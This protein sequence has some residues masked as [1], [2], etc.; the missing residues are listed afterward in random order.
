MTGEL[1]DL[2]PEPSDRKSDKPKVQGGAPRL[3]KPQRDQVEMHFAALDDLLES[4]HPA[5]AVW[6]AVEEL[7]LSPWLREVQAVEGRP[8]RNA[9]DPRV[10]LAVWVYA[11]LEAVGSARRLAKLCDPKG[12]QLGYRW[13][14]GGVTLNYHTLSDFRA[15]NAE[16][17]DGLL[18]QLVATLVH[19]GLVTMN[20]VAQDGMRVKANAGKSSF[21]R[22]VSLRNCLAE[23]KAQVKILRRLIDEDPHELSQREKAAQERAARSRTQRI[24]R[25]I[26]NCK[27]LQKNREERAEVDGQPAKEARAS[28]TDPDARNMK[29]PDGG[30]APGHNVQFCTDVESGIIVGVD[31]TNSG[32]DSRQCTPM[33]DQLQQRYNRFPQEVLIDGGFASLETIENLGTR[34]CTVYAPVKDEKKQRASG[35]DPFAKKRGDTSVVAKWRERMGTELAKLIYRE[36]SKTA[37]W[38]NA[39]ARNR[40]LYR[41]PVRGSSKCRTV[42][43]LYAIAHNFMQA[44]RLRSINSPA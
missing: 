33:M 1:F 35:K 13:L 15:E 36:R 32:N 2:G 34:G 22:Y 37:E 43:V 6:A 8:G 40:G 31:I 42:S 3:R 11:T 27:A 28:T 26:K 29:F 12:G 23:A 39:Q 25:A 21:R 17:W 38:V 24:Q 9:T 7:D 5:R 16:A 14:C 18:T 19:E 20:R 10:L 30:Y 4:D 44:L 41:M